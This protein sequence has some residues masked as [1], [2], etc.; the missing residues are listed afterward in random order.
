MDLLVVD[1]GGRRN[2]YDREPEMVELFLLMYS[3]G[4]CVFVGDGLMG[5]VVVVR[6]W[7]ISP[8][9]LC[10]SLSSNGSE[11]LQK[12]YGVWSLL[13][14]WWGRGGGIGAVIYFVFL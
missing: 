12:K 14:G 5:F 2:S 1:K 4:V 7:C 11:T 10:K 8:L 13:K 3:L 6:G 9:S